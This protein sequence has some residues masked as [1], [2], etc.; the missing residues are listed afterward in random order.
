VLQQLVDAPVLAKQSA[1]PCFAPR[2]SYRT[3]HW[4]KQKERR[5]EGR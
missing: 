3:S 4:K 5:K 1:P 2:Q